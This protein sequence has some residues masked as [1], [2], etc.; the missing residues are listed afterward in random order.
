MENMLKAIRQDDIQNIFTANHAAIEETKSWSHDKY[1][2]RTYQYPSG[3]AC[4]NFTHFK[5]SFLKTTS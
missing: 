4:I 2:S 5:S 1:K 3:I